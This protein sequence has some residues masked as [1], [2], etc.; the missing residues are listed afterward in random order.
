MTPKR[1]HFCL[2]TLPKDHVLALPR[3]VRAGGLGG[4]GE[5]CLIVRFRRWL[6]RSVC[7]SAKRRKR[8]GVVN[9]GG[10]NYLPQ[11][12]VSGGLY[13]AHLETGRRSKWLKCWT[14]EK[15]LTIGA[16][17]KTNHDDDISVGVQ[18]S[19]V[20]KFVLHYYLPSGKRGF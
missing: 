19:F 12:R 10:H 20:E 14:G 6:L 18:W 16:R 8:S 9:V 13:K 3:P 7:E 17:N 15:G 11:S 5:I 4:P 1:N 2:R